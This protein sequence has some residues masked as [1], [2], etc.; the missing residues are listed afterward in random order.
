MSISG[1]DVTIG[2]DSHSEWYV[3]CKFQPEGLDAMD[4]IGSLNLTLTSV[5]WLRIKDCWSGSYTRLLR[6]GLGVTSLT[7]MRLEAKRIPVTLDR[8]SFANMSQTYSGFTGLD[9]KLVGVASLAGGSLDGMTSLQHLTLD[10][11]S[12]K[13][14]P[15]QLLA[16]LTDLR[17]LTIYWNRQAL[18]LDTFL[19]FF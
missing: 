14:L 17:N 13:T 11:T 7:H 1:G 8:G 12:V 6:H 3:S 19:V 5:E 2:Q 15:E 4:E 9:L 18:F 16:K 10:R